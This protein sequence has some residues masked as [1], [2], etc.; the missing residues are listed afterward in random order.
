MKTVDTFLLP[1]RFFSLSSYV[2]S[3]L[4]CSIVDDCYMGDIGDI[5]DICD[6]CNIGNR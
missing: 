5:S 4:R 3:L 1:P 2:P 6:I